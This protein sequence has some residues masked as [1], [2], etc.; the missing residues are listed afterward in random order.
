MRAGGGAAAGA[1]VTRSPAPLQGITSWACASLAF[2]QR[3]NHAWH[4]NWPE[5]DAWQLQLV[6]PEGGAAEA[7]CTG[8]RLRPRQL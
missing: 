4:G 8:L 5:R 3:E 6:R 1:A 2:G 7:N